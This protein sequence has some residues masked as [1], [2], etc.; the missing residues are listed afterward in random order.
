MILTCRNAFAE[1]E[2]LQKTEEE[3]KE[4]PAAA[5]RK[6]ETISK[7]KGMPLELQWASI[8]MPL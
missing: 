2:A 5:Q 7:W 4:E 6:K 8:V 3:E 1:W